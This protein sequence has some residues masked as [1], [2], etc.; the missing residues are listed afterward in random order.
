MFRRQLHFLTTK[1][2]LGVLYSQVAGIYDPPP[3]I[4]VERLDQPL[5]KGSLDAARLLFKRMVTLDLQAASII[6]FQKSCNILF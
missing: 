1:P 2:I 3:N 4:C 6:I 5:K